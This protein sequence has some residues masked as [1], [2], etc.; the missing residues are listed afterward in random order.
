ML[1]EADS[2][3][4]SAYFAFKFDVFLLLFLLK[5]NNKKRIYRI[6]VNEIAPAI[7]EV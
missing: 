2:I 3:F 4:L 1:A 5:N 6:N 7:Y